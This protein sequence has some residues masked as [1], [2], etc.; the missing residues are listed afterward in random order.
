MKG[1]D[2]VKEALKEGDFSWSSHALDKLN[3]YGYDE[4][5]MKYLT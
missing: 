4:I 1:F 5:I 2:K 3:M